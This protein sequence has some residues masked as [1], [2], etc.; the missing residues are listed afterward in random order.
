MEM[1][2]K[3]WQVLREMSR[4]LLNGVSDTGMGYYTVS[5]TLIDEEVALL[6]KISK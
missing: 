3:E 1:T 5:D 2:S 6:K 4:N